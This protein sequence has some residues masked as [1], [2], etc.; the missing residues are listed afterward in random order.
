MSDP[1][2]M[3]AVS[4]HIGLLRESLDEALREL[5]LERDCFY[6]SVS[7][8]DGT[9]TDAHDADELAKLDRVIDKAQRALDD[10]RMEAAPHDTE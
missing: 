9:V 8:P 4:R 10:T 1:A 7:L 6:D 5:R 2:Q 3:N